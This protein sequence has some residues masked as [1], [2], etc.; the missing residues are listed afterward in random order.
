[1]RTFP[2]AAPAAAVDV[3]ACCNDPHA[4]RTTLSSWRAVLTGRFSARASALSLVRVHCL[5][6]ASRPLLLLRALARCIRALACALACALARYRNRSRAISATPPNTP[7]TMRTIVPL[8]APWLLL[9]ATSWL[10]S[11]WLRAA[12]AGGGVSGGGVMGTGDG[13]GGGEGGGGATTMG[14]TT[15]VCVPTVGETATTLTPRVDES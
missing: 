1:M 9:A 4:R 10:N 13:G 15:F 3:S 5:T 12:R 14:A 11:V 6:A 2:E 7:M 8:E